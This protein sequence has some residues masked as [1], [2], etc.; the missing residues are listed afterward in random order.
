MNVGWEEILNIDD[1]FI[2]VLIPSE[3]K[4]FVVI[5]VGVLVV[6]IPLSFRDVCPQLLVV[7]PPFA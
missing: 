2:S 3:T 6:D 7:C 4:H 1:E 5:G